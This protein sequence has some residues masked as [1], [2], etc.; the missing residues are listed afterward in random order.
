MP[1]LGNLMIWLFTGLAEFFGKYLTKK[2]AMGLA[3]VGVFSTLS[4]G[5]LT[6]ASIVITSLVPAMPGGQFV[7]LALW[8]VV[9]DN[10]PAVVSAC[11]ATDAAVALYRWNVS[12][13]H[14]VNQA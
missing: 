12:S 5:L 6:L 13:L 14:I 10:G 11:L 1:I 2:A 4:G 3:A 8:L 9:P 7:S